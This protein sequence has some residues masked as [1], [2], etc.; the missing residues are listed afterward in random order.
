MKLQLTQLGKTVTIETAHDDISCSELVQELR[1]LL[2]AQD[3]HP[4]L[5]AEHM[6][7]EEMIGNIIMDEVKKELDSG[8]CHRQDCPIN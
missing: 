8:Q 4:G 6:P 7:D 2:L 3:Y 1:C 5:V